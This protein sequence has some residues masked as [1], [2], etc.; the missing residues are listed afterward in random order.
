MINNC[1]RDFCLI[2]YWFILNSFCTDVRQTTKIAPLFR[3]F[4]VLRKKSN[5]IIF[6]L[7]IS[8]KVFFLDALPKPTALS[9]IKLHLFTLRF[10][11]FWSSFVIYINACYNNVCLRFADN[12]IINFL[13]P[14]SKLFI[15]HIKICESK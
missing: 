4:V 9:H 12:I 8:R 6:F 5:I 14:L 13:N 10:Y 3:V 15:K 2:K 1:F 7:L 11:K